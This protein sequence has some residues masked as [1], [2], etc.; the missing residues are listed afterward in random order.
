MADT[1]DALTGPGS[2]GAELIAEPFDA[3]RITALRHEVARCAG[4][5]GLDG[6]LLEDFVLAI[7]ELVTNAVRHGG[8]HGFLRLW[9]TDDRLVCE[10]TDK[11]QGIAEGAGNGRDRPSVHTV[12]GWGLW[13]ARELS[14]TMRV[15]T[16]PEGTTVQISAVRSANRADRGAPPD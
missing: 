7:N 2:E 12:G 15:A 4:S 3:A 6:N 8:G 10:V 5:A 9:L 16:G 11:G 14:D 1:E 13:L